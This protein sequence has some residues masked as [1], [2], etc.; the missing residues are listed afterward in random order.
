M[1]SIEQWLKYNKSSLLH[2]LNS[3]VHTA[4]E[5]L[6]GWNWYTISW[7]QVT[8]N[9]Y[10][11][12]SSYWTISVQGIGAASMLHHISQQNHWLL[13]HDNVWAPSS[14]YFGEPLFKFGSYYHFYPYSSQPCCSYPYHYFFCCYHHHYGPDVKLITDILDL[15]QRLQKKVRLKR[16]PHSLL[17]PQCVMY[18][19]SDSAST[20]LEITSK[21]SAHMLRQFWRVQ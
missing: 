21:A 8:V 15:K 14:T 20:V 6:M 3:K 5:V 13:S 11:I 10:I 4:S 18:P 9:H 12:L 7:Q 17:L 19:I 16:T 1:Q 2:K